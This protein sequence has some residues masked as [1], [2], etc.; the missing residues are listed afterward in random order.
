MELRIKRKSAIGWAPHERYRQVLVD[1]SGQERWS[2]IVI[3]SY[4]GRSEIE[5]DK[6]M[7]SW[8][9][10]QPEYLDEQVEWEEATRQLERELRHEPTNDE[11]QDRVQMNKETK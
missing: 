9:C 2:C 1:P 6:M 4:S 5:A 7:H 3:N 10:S 11:I 8:I